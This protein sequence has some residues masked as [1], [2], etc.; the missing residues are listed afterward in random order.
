ME[1]GGGEDVG[2]CCAT[3]RGERAR[4]ALLSH[5][6]RNLERKKEIYWFARAVVTKYHRLGSL[7]NRYLLAY[8]SGDQN[9]KI[10]V[11]GGSIS[12]VSSLPGLQMV[13]FFPESLH[14]LASVSVCS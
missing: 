1:V 10:K 14:G 4:E 9:S 5:Q 6:N 2:A 3:S 7:N 8:S 12:S 11:L 13:I